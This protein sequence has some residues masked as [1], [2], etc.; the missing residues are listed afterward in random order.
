VT[1]VLPNEVPTAGGVGVTVAGSG[2]GVGMVVEV[3]GVRADSTLIDDGLIRV[4]VPRH[5]PG[6][7]SVAVIDPAGLEDALA[8]ALLYV[9]PP[10]E[11]APAA[12]A[13]AEPAAAGSRRVAGGCVAAPGTA[14]GCPGQWA[15]LAVAVA[16]TRRSRRA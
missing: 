11:P 12:E 2:F 15:L 16:L 10:T 13:P 6:M 3:D 4:I 5:A 1:T 8:G 7:A 14:A 9:P